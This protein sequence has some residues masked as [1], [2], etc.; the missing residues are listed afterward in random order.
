[1][2]AGIKFGALFQCIYLINDSSVE[3]ISCFPKFPFGVLGKPQ[4][5]RWVVFPA[6]HYIYPEHI[7]FTYIYLHSL[8]VLWRDATPRVASNARETNHS[9]SLWYSSNY[10]PTLDKS[11]VCKWECLFLPLSSAPYSF[12]AML[13]FVCNSL[14]RQKFGSQRG[15]F[16]AFIFFLLPLCISRG[17]R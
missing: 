10:P 12:Q 2:N 5:H 3:I 15:Q 7:L 16:C 17:N 11:H 8:Q 1:V 14:K 9:K 6:W 4:L 13:W